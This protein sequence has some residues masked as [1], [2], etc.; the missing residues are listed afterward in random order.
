M[1]K[2]ITFTKHKFLMIIACILDFFD[3]ISMK[4]DMTGTF[5]KLGGILTV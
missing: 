3:V 2:K 5:P 1:N 4:A